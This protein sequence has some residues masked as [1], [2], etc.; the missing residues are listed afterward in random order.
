MLLSCGVKILISSSICQ[1]HNDIALKLF[2]QF[3][4]LYSSLY[5]E[6]FISYNVHSLLQLPMFVRIHGPLDNF[7]CFKYENCLQYIKK[8][9]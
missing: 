9:H 1:T 3:I 4:T 5:G 6:Q 8:I 7:S 2:K